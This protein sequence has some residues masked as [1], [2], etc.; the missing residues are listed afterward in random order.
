M[1]EINNER[2]VERFQAMLRKRTVSDKDGK[3]DREVFASYLP[4]LK[5]M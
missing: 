5:E 3:F 2:A 1:A 4:M